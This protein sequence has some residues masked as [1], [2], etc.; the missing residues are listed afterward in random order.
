MRCNTFFVLIRRFALADATVERGN[1]GEG[2]GFEISVGVQ[3]N[4]SQIQEDVAEDVKKKKKKGKLVSAIRKAFHFRRNSNDST[5]N[6]FVPLPAYSSTQKTTTTAAT[7]SV[8]TSLSTDS[9]TLITSNA[10]NTSYITY[11]LTSRL[12]TNLGLAQ[13]YAPGLEVRSAHIQHD[14]RRYAILTL[15]SSQLLKSITSLFKTSVALH[16]PV[17]SD[18]FDSLQIDIE[19]LTFRWFQTLFIIPS[20]PTSTVCSLFDTFVVT[21]R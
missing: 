18:H 7:T 21:R 12:F 15:L 3:K 16:L 17:L 20:I 2:E 5:E 13:F 4:M 6:S 9:T 11:K 19:P 10:S 14:H 8:A 1:E